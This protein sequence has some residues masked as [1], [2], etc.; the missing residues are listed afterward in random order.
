MGR[1]TRSISIK[2]EIWNQAL[3]QTDNLSQTI[4]QLLQKH[5]LHQ[6]TSSQP[7]P[8]NLLNRSELT[9]K[10]HRAVKKLIEKEISEITLE[11]FRNLVLDE[12]LYHRR[13][14]IKKAVQ[15]IDRDPMVPFKLSGG[16]FHQKSIRCR[17]GAVSEPLALENGCC[18]KCGLQLIDLGEGEND[19]PTVEVLWA[20]EFT[21]R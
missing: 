17:C 7:E 1:T 11:S 16:S 18:P 4:E 12:G 5:V 15:R 19:D 10:Q 3:E 8:Y 14:F 6:E 9:D 20:R 2:E 21:R 13:D